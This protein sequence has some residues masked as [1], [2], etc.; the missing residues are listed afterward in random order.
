[1]RPK[2]IKDLFITAKIWLNDQVVKAVPE[3]A[4]IKDG[5]SSFIY[6]AK[7]NDKSQDMDFQKIMV[8]PGTSESGK[9]AIKL[10]DEIPKGMKIVT[11]GAYYVYAQSKAGELTH[12]H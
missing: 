6:I 5:A 10:I 1:M 4:V 12:E 7:E 11:K 9:T 8:I 3:D 2:F